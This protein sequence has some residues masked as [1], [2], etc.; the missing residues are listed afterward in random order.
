MEKNDKKSPLRR[1][2]AYS[3]PQQTQIILASMCSILN[4]IFDLAPPV[5][6]GMAVDVVVQQEDSFLGNLGMTD[7]TVQLVILGILTIAAWGLESF[8]NTFIAF[9]GVI[10]HKLY[11][12]ICV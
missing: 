6:I 8:F 4:Q 10:W 3:R 1:L 2:L 11:S 9:Y 5:L 7:P 12:M